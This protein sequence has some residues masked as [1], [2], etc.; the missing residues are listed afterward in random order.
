MSIHVNIVLTGWWLV[1]NESK[2]L[3]WFPAPYLENAEA[4]DEAAD[5]EVGESKIFDSILERIV[6]RTFLRVVKLCSTGIRPISRNII[7]LQT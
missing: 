6:L 5:E 3:A 7:S 2:F 4:E 1:E